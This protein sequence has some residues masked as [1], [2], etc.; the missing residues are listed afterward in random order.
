MNK[1]EYL[2]SMLKS[3]EHSQ[4][5]LVSQ[6]NAEKRA[7]RAAEKKAHDADLRVSD[8]T[9]R[10]TELESRLEAQLNKVAEM[11]QQ[12]TT[13]LMGGGALSLPESLKEELVGTIRAEFDRQIQE[14]K[15]M[16]EKEKQDLIA[17]FNARLAAKDNEIARLKGEDG[18]EDGQPPSTT[19]PGSSAPLVPLLQHDCFRY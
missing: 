10:N 17:S 9:T 18:N 12:I 16:H 19:A 6:L 15:A 5:I 11:V 8:L 13:M 7:R 1:N 4:Q 2:C 14:L 3:E